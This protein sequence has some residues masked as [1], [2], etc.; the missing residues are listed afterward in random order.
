MGAALGEPPR[1]PADHPADVLERLFAQQLHR[2]A[3]SRR[4]VLLVDALDQFVPTQ[5]ARA[6][7]WI[8]LPWPR[9]ARLIVTTVPGEESAALALHAGVTTVPIPPLDREDSRD[10][11][12]RVYGRYH[13]K[14]NDGVLA[15]LLS[16]RHP[17]GTPASDNPLWLSLALELLNQFGGDDFAEAEKSFAGSAEER[18]RLLTLER[19]RGLPPDMEGLY[20]S[21]LAY[22]E[23]V[24]GAVET[25]AFAT[26]ITL[27]RNGW[28]E[29]DFRHLLP[30]V[31]DRL[32]AA[33]KAGPSE[34]PRGLAWDPLRFATLRRCFRAHVVLRGSLTQWDFAHA[35]LRRAIHSCYPVSP[36]EQKVLHGLVLDYFESVPPGD[37]LPGR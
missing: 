34:S 14:P 8:P 25:R 6:V 30:K 26:L 10:L 20:R 28:R 21:L 16:L 7:S 37:P 35:T 32:R 36:E 17:D 31:A 22:V 24:A 2:V 12:G 13:R 23:K 27:G 29:Q 1:L 4:V 15:E 19:A 3:A 11:A 18:L 5:R 9:N 33:G